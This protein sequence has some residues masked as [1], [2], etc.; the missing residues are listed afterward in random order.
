MQAAAM[1]VESFEARISKQ[2]RLRLTNSEAHWVR[3]VLG[4]WESDAGAASSMGAQ[5]QHLA[6]N[7]AVGAHKRAPVA[8]GEQTIFVHHVAPSMQERD[9][10]QDRYCSKRRAERDSIRRAWLALAAMPSRSLVVLNALYG[11][12][13]PGMHLLDRGLWPKDVDDEYRRVARAVVGSLAAF[14]ALLRVSVAKR[15]G[16]AAAAAKA[17]LEGAKAER[18][19]LVKDV[20]RQCEQAIVRAAVE[21]RGAWEASAA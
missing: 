17:R 8:S 12:L 16:E 9:W 10:P 7:A 5:L 18:G 11:G 13:P 3:Y 4:E 1:K 14:A 19:A 2:S 6:E 20:G 15:E 21:Y